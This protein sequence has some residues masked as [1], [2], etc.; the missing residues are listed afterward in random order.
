MGKQDGSL[1]REAAMSVVLFGG[2][3]ANAGHQLIFESVCIADDPLF[4][5]VKQ[6]NAGTGHTYSKQSHS[7]FCG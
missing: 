6:R 3:H 1:S 7:A 5:A 2:Q 4:F